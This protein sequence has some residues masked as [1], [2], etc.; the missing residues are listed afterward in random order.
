M[1]IEN[2]CIKIKKINDL[3]ALKKTSQ[4]N[5]FEKN[6]LNLSLKQRNS[7]TNRHAWSRLKNEIIQKENIDRHR[8]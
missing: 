4:N 2:L 6:A 5:A 8:P 1:E 7:K 3:F